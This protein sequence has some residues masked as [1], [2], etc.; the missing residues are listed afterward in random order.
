[1]S[2][3]A[4]AQRAHLAGELAARGIDCHTVIVAD[5]ENLD[6]AKDHGFDTVEMDNDQGLGRRFNAGFQ[7]A[8][9]EGA[10]W[11]VH[12]GSDDWIHPDAF[13]PILDPPRPAAIVTG[14]RMMFV[15]LLTGEAR[16]ARLDG[17]QGVIPW[18]VPR[19]MMQPSGFA[20]IRPDRL[21]GMDGYLIRGMRKS[22]ARVRWH[23][24]DPHDMAR[25]DFKSDVNLN[26]YAAISG[27]FRGTDLDPWT[28]LAERYPADLVDMARLA[29]LEFLE[30]QCP[31]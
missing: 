10:D 13:T 18:I 26:T 23:V 17:P 12:I 28:G 27:F 24:H 6:L 1:M 22:G 5:D 11:L 8:A 31:S 3:I 15:D 21:R 9:N 30:A 7:H 25:V 2:R 19:A 4:F 20:P 16:R 14:R 29:H